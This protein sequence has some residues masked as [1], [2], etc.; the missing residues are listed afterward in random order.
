MV[1]VYYHHASCL[2]SAVLFKYW[3]CISSVVDKFKILWLKLYNFPLFANKKEDLSNNTNFGCY[4]QLP[5]SSV[6][7]LLEGLA[8]ILIMLSKTD[9]LCL[10]KIKQRI[11]T[12]VIAHS[13][14]HHPLAADGIITGLFIDL[15]REK[16]GYTIVPLNNATD[17]F[18]VT[19]LR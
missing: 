14:T 16:T 8:P 2:M 4:S 19:F 6:W 15:K 3:Y 12:Q 18:W 17:L 11:C 7:S 10:L 1:I 13:D 5:I 9:T